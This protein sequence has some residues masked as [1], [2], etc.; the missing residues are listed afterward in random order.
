MSDTIEFQLPNALWEPAQ[1]EAGQIFNAMRVGE[2]QY[3]RPNIS[4][5]MA[6]LQP[7]ASLEDAVANVS[8]RL[9]TLDPS[10]KVVKRSV[11]EAEGSALQQVDLNVQVAPDVRRSISQAQVFTV[12]EDQESDR[13]MVLCLM[14]TAESDT[15]DDYLEDFQA[16]VQSVHAA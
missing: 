7:E 3:F 8:Q 15:L 4:G 1:P 14:L 12:M 9:Q 5:D 13:R 2:F 6:E 16:F 10:V 11:D